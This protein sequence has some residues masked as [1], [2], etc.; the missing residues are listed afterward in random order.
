MHAQEVNSS[1]YPNGPREKRVEEKK[2]TV[3]KKQRGNGV[4]LP[5]V[6]RQSNLY[7]GENGDR[8]TILAAAAI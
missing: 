6:Q 5:Y 8:T 4:S 1:H 3:K 7:D 2:K